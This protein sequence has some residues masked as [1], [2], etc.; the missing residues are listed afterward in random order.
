MCCD[1]RLRPL[2]KADIGGA[3]RDVRYAPKAD[4]V[5]SALNARFVPP[6]SQR[7]AANA[8]LF[9]HFVGAG[10]HGQRHG[11]SQRLGGLQVDH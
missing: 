5:Q 6:A 7:T 1:D 2:P 10:E 3:S 11:K 9:D 4:M 8:P